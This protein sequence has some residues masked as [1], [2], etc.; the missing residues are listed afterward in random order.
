MNY[1]E[2]I[3]LIKVLDES[4][5]KTFEINFENAYINLSKLGSKS[6]N[7]IDFNSIDNNNKFENNLDEN[8]EGPITILPNEK[9][10]ILEGSV[11]KSPIVGTFYNSS[12]PEK[13]PYVKVGDVVKKGDV[14]CIVEAMKVMN[15]VKSE[16]DGIIKDVLI[17]NEN[18]VEYGQPLFIIG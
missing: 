2:V 3:N 11:V 8:I 14:L 1:N 9:E 4:S 6:K 16:F 17:E 18:I 12:S 15:E 7:D 10:D 13:P 5:I